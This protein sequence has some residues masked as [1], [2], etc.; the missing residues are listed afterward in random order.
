MVESLQP[1]KIKKVTPITENQKIYL[2][3]LENNI[4]T[5]VKGFAG[6]GKSFLAATYAA[7]ELIDPDSKVKKIVVVRPYVD[8]GR[9]IGFLKGDEYDK[10]LP[11]VRQILE[12]IRYITGDE[13][14]ANFIETGAV[15][16][17]A[18]SSIRG[19]SYSNTIILCDEMQN[20]TYGE[21]QA[22][23]TRI[24]KDSKMVIMGDTKQNDIKKPDINDGISYLMDILTRYNIRKSGIIEL[25]KDDIVR[26]GITRDFVL[27]YDKDGWK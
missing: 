5:V 10:M 26:S 18:L 8:L 27:A 1:H 17:K 3:S 13:K 25:G 7:Q 12:G 19:M 24:G 4:L 14:Y 16:V 9:S 23:T 21:I 22:L 2:S 20:A 15:E 6:T 11:Y